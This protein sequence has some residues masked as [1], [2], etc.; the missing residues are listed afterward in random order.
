MMLPSLRCPVLEAA[1]AWHREGRA[2]YVVE[3]ADVRGSAPRE[4]GTRMLVSGDEAVGTIGG[5]HLEWE[6]VAEARA[7]LRSGAPVRHARRLSLGASLG[8]CCGGAVAVQYHLLDEASLAAWPHQEALFALQLHG[9]GHVGQAIVR[10]LEALP[11]RVQW[12]DCRDQVA[13]VPG[14]CSDQRSPSITCTV[15]ERP[16]QDVR[17]MPP[18][19]L[20]LVMTHDH[21]LDGRIVEAILRRGDA[22]YCGMIGSMTKRRRFEHRLL[23][24]GLSASSVER[25][26]CPIGVPGIAGKAP[27]IIAVA[28]VAEL[29]QHARLT[30]PAQPSNPDAVVNP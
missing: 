1:R 30:A 26:V 8:Q 19:A 3:L 27:E 22:A 12:I 10:L 13:G 17:D 14:W 2:A 9:A 29:L 24:R 5:G 18:G 23:A 16:E 6:L 11:V 7:L 4:A 20:Y 15:S 28:V 25:L 21:D